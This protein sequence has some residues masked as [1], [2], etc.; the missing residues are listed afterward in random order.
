[1]TWTIGFLPRWVQM[2]TSWPAYCQLQFASWIVFQY[3]YHLGSLQSSRQSAVILT[4]CSHLRAL[5]LLSTDL[6]IALVAPAYILFSLRCIKYHEVQ[7]MRDLPPRVSEEQLKWVQVTSY[8]LHNSV[9]LPR[10]LLHSTLH[11]LLE[12][13]GLGHPYIHYTAMVAT[14]I[15]CMIPFEQRNVIDNELPI[16][17]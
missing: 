12:G 14:V 15:P 17:P 9:N 8:H 10:H 4:V 5:L 1:M 16:G 6:V 7:H 2:R 11:L 13:D 3:P